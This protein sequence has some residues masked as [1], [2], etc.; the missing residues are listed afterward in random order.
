VLD[1]DLIDFLI[2][3]EEERRNALR[4]LG[5]IKGRRAGLTRRARQA[6]GEEL[7]RRSRPP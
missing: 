2:L 4:L 3:H 5:E 7:A 1:Y 6:N